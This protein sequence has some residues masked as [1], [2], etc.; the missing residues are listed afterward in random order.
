MR[1]PLGDAV[2]MAVVQAQSFASRIACNVRAHAM[3]F[4]RYSSRATMYC[5]EAKLL[6]VH[7]M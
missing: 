5:T 1:R 2:S 7:Q 3:P 6:S 4:L